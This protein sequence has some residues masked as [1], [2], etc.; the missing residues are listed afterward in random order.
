M[1]RVHLLLPPVK[2]LPALSS[3]MTSWKSA[4]FR[5]E[6]CPLSA[7]LQ[8]SLCFFQPPLPADPTVFL[9]EPPAS[10]RRRSDG[11]S[12]FDCND[13]NELVPA[14]HTG[15]LDCPCAPCVRG[16]S[17]LRCRFWPEPVSV[18][19]SLSMTMPEAVHFCWTYHSACLS[20]HIDAR[21]REEHL[22][23]FPSSS[24]SRD[25]VLAAS[26]RTVASNVSANRLLWTEPQVPLTNRNSYR[27]II[28]ISSCH[29]HAL[30]LPR[31]RAFCP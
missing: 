4:H 10:Q 19:G 28:V 20:D 16:S 31:A 12:M 24:R 7:R 8:S 6:E 2:D 3:S 11:F 17:R 1:L 22:A 21:S 5:G 23:E 30:L 27:T 14:F 25:V 26:D 13:T 29:T 9:A 15:S 18:F